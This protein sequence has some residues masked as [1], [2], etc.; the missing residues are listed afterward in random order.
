M[1][2]N[3]PTSS[4][5]LVLSALLSVHASPVANNGLALDARD[6]VDSSFLQRAAVVEARQDTATATATDAV[7][8]SAT[9]TK[10]AKG[11][12]AAVVST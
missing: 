3:I 2:F 7:T 10:K 4:L 8:A 9:K 11:T 1:Q 6:I 12:K 5:V